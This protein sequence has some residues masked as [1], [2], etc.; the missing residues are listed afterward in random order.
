[1]NRVILMGRL[2]RDPEGRS[3]TSGARIVS[4]SLATDERVKDGNEWKTVPTWHRVVC[5]G[6]TGEAAEKH[7][8]KG[9]RVLVEGRISYRE[10]DGKDGKVVKTTEILADRVQ[11]IDWPERE[12]GAPRREADPTSGWSRGGQ[13]SFDGDDDVAF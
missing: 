1:M 11:V 5:F 13:Q 3:T 9:R 7:C 12:G 2:G 6:K 8:G 4:L 10:F